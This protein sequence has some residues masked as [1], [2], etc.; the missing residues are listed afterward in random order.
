[1]KRQ[2]IPVLMAA[3]LVG[4]GMAATTAHADSS[5]PVADFFKKAQFAGAPI[6]S[7]DGKNMAV[8]TP[9]NG[10]NVLAVI[11]LDTRVPKVVAADPDWNISN[12]IWVNSNRLV[13]S[14]TRGSDEVL[15]RQT[16]GGLFAVNTDGSGFKKLAMTIKEA[17]GGNVKYDGISVLQRAGGESADLFVVNNERG[18]D[19]DLGASDVFRLD[20]TNG[21]RTLLTFDNPGNVSGWLLD[22][23]NVIRIASALSVAPGTNRIQQTVS[24]RESDKSPWRPIHQGFLDEGKAMT[25][26]GFDFN[27]K[28][29]YVSGRFNGGDRETAH[30]WN[31]STNTPGEMIADHPLVDVSG[32]LLFDEVRKKI[33][34]MRVNGMKPETYYFDEDYARMQATL[35]ASLPGQDVT[36]SW[37][38]ER[39]VLVARGD[40]NVGKV[41]FFDLKKQRLEPV[42]DFKPEF[43][44]KRLSAQ[45]V[46]DYKARDGLSIPAY[47]TLPEGMPAK[48]LPLVMFVHGG[49]HA[50]DSFGYNPLT[51]ML[52]S[53]GYAVL[54]PQFRMS[55]GFGWKHHTAGWKQ[56]GLAMQ[57]DLTD[58]VEALAKQGVIDK[59]R[60]CIIGASY[61]GYATMYGLVKDPDLYKCGIN[62]VGVTDV[63]MLF[64]VTWSDMRGPYM[65]NMGAKMHG[66]PKTDEAYFQKVSAIENAARIKAP[67]LMAYGSE[68]VRVPLI[69]GEKMRDVLRKQ[70]NTAEFMVMTGEGHGWQKESNNIL[71]G[72]TVLNFIDRYIGPGAAKGK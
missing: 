14:I 44:G 35:N 18:R 57:D 43:E 10:R 6:L 68:D 62:W 60:V 2:I 20:T 11:N 15:E 16:G 56:W 19:A 27:N 72:N 59:N 49:P 38:G 24:Y 3:L 48:N 30:V 46:I 36:F 8:L 25:P 21:R 42:F 17:Q 1:M 67:V 9:R 65:D 5:I 33:I 37:R 53:R 4:T 66:D 23:D 52:A 40:N 69:H 29:M 39:V 34:G 64:T 45:T 26:L 58:G 31:F 7:P 32:G 63:K 51:Q 47:L 71:W 28:T 41:Y 12:P 70:G 50:R 22:H 13:F 54:Q 55:T 61:G